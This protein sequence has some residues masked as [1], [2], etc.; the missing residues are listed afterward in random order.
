M[1]SF[2]TNN[3]RLVQI[4]YAWIGILLPYLPPRHN[5]GVII[6]GVKI[7]ITVFKA[8]FYLRMENFLKIM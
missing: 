8:V 7:N 5:A 1:A 6:T 2:P 3:E 4:M